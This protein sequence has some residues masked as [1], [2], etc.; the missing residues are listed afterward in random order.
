M[1]PKNWGGSAP[2]MLPDV[3][4]VLHQYADEMSL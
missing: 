4:M 2:M 3:D 1:L